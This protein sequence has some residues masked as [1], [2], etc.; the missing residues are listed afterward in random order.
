MVGAGDLLIVDVPCLALLVAIVHPLPGLVITQGTI[1]WHLEERGTSLCLL[2][3]KEE[4]IATRGLLI[5]TRRDEVVLLVIGHILL[6]QRMDG[7]I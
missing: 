7:Q 6:L 2:L 5:L 1:M 4:G 3:L